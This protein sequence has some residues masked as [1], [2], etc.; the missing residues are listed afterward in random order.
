MD[1]RDVDDNVNVT[2]YVPNDKHASQTISSF[3]S[4]GFVILNTFLELLFH[5]SIHK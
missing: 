1:N 2:A 5:N 4:G 3:R